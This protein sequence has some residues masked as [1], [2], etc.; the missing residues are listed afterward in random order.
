MPR[1][2]IQPKLASGLFYFNGEPISRTA[3]YETNKEMEDRATRYRCGTC[4]KPINLHGQLLC[5]NCKFSRPA[6]PIRTTE[7]GREQ[8]LDTIG[9]ITSVADYHAK[10]RTSPT[11]PSV[12]SLSKRHREDKKEEETMDEYMDALIRRCT[13]ARERVFTANGRLVMPSR[14][15]VKATE[16]LQ[17]ESEPVVYARPTSPARSPTA[18]SRHNAHY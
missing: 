5:C 4:G 8:L 9:R 17:G 16:R 7:V 10:H 14:E 18:P 11:R 2:K 15:K 1:P 12:S 13:T 3:V 6:S